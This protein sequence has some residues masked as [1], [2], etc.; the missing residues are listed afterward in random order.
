MKISLV[1]KVERLQEGDVLYKLHA[2][3]SNFLEYLNSKE[4]DD[5]FTDDEAQRVNDIYSS[6]LG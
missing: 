3:D 2:D 6:N 5:D 1:A 4:D